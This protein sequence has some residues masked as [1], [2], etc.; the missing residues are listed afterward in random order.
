K[1]S[2]SNGVGVFGNDVKDTNIPVEVWRYYL[3]INRPEEGSDADFTWPDLQ[4]KLNNELLNNLGNFVNR[5]LSFIAKP[6]G[7]GYNS[8][9]PNVPDD[10]SGDSHN[11]TKEL[12]D[13]VSAYLDQYIEAM[14]KVK[15][16][17]GLKIAMSISKEGNAYLQ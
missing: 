6:A 17:Q 11:P 8:I 4:A 10:V 1:F 9:I 5:V 7:V 15:L 14:E 12:A 13:K 2:K 16:K 3:L